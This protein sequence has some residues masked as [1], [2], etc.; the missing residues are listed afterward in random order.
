M[1]LL[2]AATPFWKKKTR[3]AVLLPNIINYLLLFYY[4]F[5]IS[6]RKEKNKISLRVIKI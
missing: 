2:N 3:H 6:R 5:K 1:S 4:I